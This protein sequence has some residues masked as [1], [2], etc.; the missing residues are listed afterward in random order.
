MMTVRGMHHFFLM[1]AAPLLGIM[2]WIWSLEPAIMPEN[3]LPLQTQAFSIRDQ[4]SRI[5]Q[6]FSA[7]SEKALT[8]NDSLE[9]FYESYVHNVNQTN[10]MLNLTESIRGIPYAIYDRRISSMLGAPMKRISSSNIDLALYAFR[11]RNY[12]GYAMKVHLK[13]DQAMKMVLGDD[14][15]G[16][17]ET[18][19][20]ALQRYGA[21][22]AVNAGGFADRKTD[23]KRYPI[24]TTVLDGNY[25]FGFIPSRQDLFFVGL[26]KN[27]K[28]I[29]GKF[30][31]REDLE[32]LSPQFGV[33]F[34]PV[35][36]LNGEKQKIP[37]KWLVDPGRA[38]RTIL[39]NYKHDHLLFIVTDGYNVNGNLG[40][41]LA[42]IQD[43]AKQ[44]GLQ[45]AFNLD[46]GGSTTL[47]WDGKLMNTPSDGRQRLLPTHFLF[48]K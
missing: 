40:P 11:E 16:G 7:A 2:L 18:T 10:Q 44:L 26:D 3:D 6:G 30:Y 5:E 25:L 12:S 27:R 28:L 21:F 13:T 9:Q 17:S 31:K 14:T 19:L 8:A 24:G 36:L 33:S 48:F 37:D 38:P 43:K 23:G 45:N 35:L 29:G 41:T 4:V 1:L 42:E 39:G 22:A 15:P 47:V 34:V 46:G 32:Q 20:S